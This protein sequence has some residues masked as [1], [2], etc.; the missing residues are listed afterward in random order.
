MP[1]EQ[2]KKV[3]AFTLGCKVNQYDT[4][5]MLE[6]FRQRGYEVVD[7]APGADVYLINTCTVTSRSEAKSRQVLRRALRENPGAIVA[8]TGCYAQVAPAELWQI[9][10]VD[11]VI[12]THG[13]RQIVDLVEAAAKRKGRQKELKESSRPQIAA[14]RRMKMVFSEEEAEKTDGA[15]GHEA[16]ATAT[17]R[18]IFSLPAEA[19]VSVPAGK[20]DLWAERDPRQLGAA[21][22]EATAFE[23]LPIFRFT[24]R[25]RATV[26]VQEGCNQFCSYCLVPF[27]RGRS[28]SRAPQA[29]LAEARRLVEGGFKEIVLTGIHLGAYGLDL[30]ENVDLAGLV[31][32]LLAVDGLERIRLSSIEP[33]E[34]SEKLL[35]LMGGG[36]K[37]CRHL[38]IPLQSGCDSVLARMN[39]RYSTR[40]YAEVLARARAAVPGVA[41]ST[42]VMVG[43]PGE[44][45][46]EF[47]A[48]YQFVRE[49]AF[50]KVHVF[51]YSRRP[52]TR[53]A[54]FPGQ[55]SRAEKEERSRRMGEL[56]DEL[57]LAFHR[58]F[59]DRRVQVL[60][61][62]ERDESGWLEG[63]T[64]NY[65][66]VTFPGGD[67][68]VNQ[69]K[70]VLVLEADRE[71][72]RGQ[73]VSVS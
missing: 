27:A 60:V 63:L 62:A 47:Q 34:V 24:G 10:G 56:A 2:R 14:P 29:V 21:W 12:G 54:S 23:E 66:R 50:S 42:D 3:A 58:Q 18:G 16:A 64:D 57:A 7:F 11:V 36:G 44:T 65:L 20:E 67:E 71:G 51:P 59:I 69:I 25:T 38:H 61:E 6:L 43:F 26:K 13:R 4:Q 1:A 46:A 15:A 19:E 31:E 22:A 70:E 73:L 17:A 45:E 8:V 33:L 9:P 40:Q 68:N 53:A 35:E 39:R 37:V 52:G 48:S 55:L 30:D 49:M 41:I 5:A 32:K 28:R 72:A